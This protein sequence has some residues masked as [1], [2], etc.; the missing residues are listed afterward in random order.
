MP[1]SAPPIPGP[2]FERLLRALDKVAE[3][4]ADV[5]SARDEVRDL[6][7]DLERAHE[8]IGRLRSKLSHAEKVI[9]YGNGVPSI[10]SRVEALERGDKARAILIPAVTGVLVAVLAN[11]HN[12]RAAVFPKPPPPIRDTR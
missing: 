4:G 10:R 3:L 11:L 1:D 6:R 5:R 7:R 12:I 2:A 8:D 9:L